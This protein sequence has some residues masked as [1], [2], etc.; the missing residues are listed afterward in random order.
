MPPLPSAAFDPVEWRSVKAD[1][2]GTVPVDSNRYLAGPKWH[3]MR[4]HAGA[5]V[6]QIELRDPDGGHTATLERVWGRSPETQPDPAA[7]LAV[8]A[9]APVMGREPDPRGFPRTRTRPARPHGRVGTLLADLGHPAR[10]RDT[11]LPGR[12]RRRRRDH[13]DRTHHRPGDHRDHRGTHPA[14][15]RH[16]RQPGPGQIRQIHMEER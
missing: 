5:G 10:R 2:T 1:R 12:G 13:Q 14:R 11:R 15:R 8:I 16:A 3:S 7:L 4:L 9:Q 6:F